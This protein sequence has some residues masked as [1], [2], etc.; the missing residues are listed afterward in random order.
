[1]SPSESL[2]LQPFGLTWTRALIEVFL[3]WSFVFICHITSS[4][5][6]PPPFWLF[7]PPTRIIQ[8]DINLP[9]VFGTSLRRP[10]YPSLSRCR[11]PSLD[12]T[13]PFPPPLL[14]SFLYLIYLQPLIPVTVVPDTTTGP[15]SHITL[16]W[17]IASLSHLPWSSFHSHTLN[18]HPSSWCPIITTTSFP[19]NSTAVTTSSFFHIWLTILVIHP[20]SFNKLL[21]WSQ[22]LISTLILPVGTNHMSRPSTPHTPIEHPSNYNIL[23]LFSTFSI[24]NPYHHHTLPY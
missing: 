8:S 15:F 17:P 24:S 14:H 12:L 7:P 18:H 21:T 5:Q 22:H 6:P 4:R 23:L 13:S 3:Q 2:L 11:K 10:L 16:F 20:K 9:Y 19:M 1:M